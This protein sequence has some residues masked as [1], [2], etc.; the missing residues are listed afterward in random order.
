M[1]EN[2]TRI[3]KANLITFSKR[4]SLTD[5]LGQLFGTMIV[6][7]WFV[8]IY[9]HLAIALNR[10]IA[11]IFPL[12]VSSLLTQRKTAF[13]VLICW[14]LGFSRIAPRVDRKIYHSPRYNW[15]V[16]ESVK[17]VKSFPPSQ[18]STAPKQL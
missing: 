15:V 2:S 7:M 3:I 8:S 6:I 10:L 12:Q 14:M 13:V 5:L 16:N 11:I 4:E 9:C 18:A 17:S 1:D